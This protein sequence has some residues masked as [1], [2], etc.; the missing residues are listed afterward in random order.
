LLDVKC[1]C[2]YLKRERENY[3]LV[4]ILSESPWPVASYK[5]LPHRPAFKYD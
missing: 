3:D 5:L 1:D 4:K 2:V